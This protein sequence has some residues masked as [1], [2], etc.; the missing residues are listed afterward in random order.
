MKNI[1]SSLLSVSPIFLRNLALLAILITEPVACHRAPSKQVASA[2]LLHQVQ[3]LLRIQVEDAGVTF[4]E[5]LLKKGLTELP[6]NS[7]VSRLIQDPIGG[8][9]IG[10][11]TGFEVILDPW[12]EP[13]MLALRGSRESAR[14]APELLQ[15][16]GL[17]LIWSKGPNRVDE[18]GNGDDV[19]TSRYFLT[20]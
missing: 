9:P 13:L 16:N 14:L 6:L 8:K 10:Y 20:P 7:A 15:E 19:I 3:L 5:L 11:G 1:V 17:I 12:G 2:T 4:N 18:N